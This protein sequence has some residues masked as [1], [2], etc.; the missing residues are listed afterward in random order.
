MSEYHVP[1]MLQECIEGL[2]IEENGIYVD[3]T[4]GGGGHSKEI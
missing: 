1:V 4:L 3:V 2:A